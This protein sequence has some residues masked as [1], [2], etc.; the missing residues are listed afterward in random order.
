M[1]ENLSLLTYTHSNCSDVHKMYLDS[2]E[3]YYTN[4]RH[5]VLSN[6]VIVDNR[7]K[8]IIYNDTD[9]Y[10]QILLSLSK[11]DTEYLIYSQED[12]ILYDK[13]NTVLLNECIEILNSDE[14][15]MF[16]R[17]IDSG[18]SGNEKDYSDKFL[19][20]D[21]DSEYFF[22]TQITLWRKNILKKMFESSKVK[23]ISDE[24][25]NSPFLSSLGGIGLCT[26]LKGDRIGGH[27]N[28]VIYPYTAVAILQG[29]WNFSEYG[30][31]LEKLLDRYKIDKNKRGIR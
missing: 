17:L 22:S 5:Y 13:V 15:V 11:I 21:K 24:T 28:S 1:I 31:I 8:Q 9:Y 23:K 19:I 4:E 25:K 16:I 30:N 26:K 7:I 27:H 10:E 3:N 29:K 20:V 14:N 12:Y 18:M 2:I 6:E